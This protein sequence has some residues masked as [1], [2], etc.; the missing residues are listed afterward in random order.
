LA[1]KI[2]S[3]VHGEYAALTEQLE[4]DDTAVFLGDYVNLID[5]QTLE[6][7][8]TEVYSREE[9]L[10]ALGILNQGKKED[11]DEARRQIRE[12]VGSD[13]EKAARVGQLVV[14]SYRELFACIPCRAY[15]I[16]GNTDTP[17]M[18]RELAYGNVEVIETGV[19]E[20]EGQSFGFISGSPHGPWT[21]GLPGEMDVEEYD[22]RVRSLGPVDVLC[23]H[24]PPAI[25]ELTWDLLA[26]RDETGSVALLEYVNEHSPSHHYFGHVHHPRESTGVRGATCL[27]NAGFFRE[28]RTA[29]VHPFEC[30][31]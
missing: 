29:V 18:V 30:G 21:V 16:Y 6:G 20:I 27:V 3:D 5:F 9:V 7:I 25:P 24:Y 22:K 14:A 28:H 17:Q 26:N 19:A 8:L 2:I 31:F 23:T 12:V 1:I 4:P 13:M 11:R 10:R 15:M